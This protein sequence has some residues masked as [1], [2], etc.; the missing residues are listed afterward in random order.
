MLDAAHGASMS[1]E[2]IRVERGDV[3]GSEVHRS[4]TDTAGSDRRRR[5][6]KPV[7]ADIRQYCRRRVADARSRDGK[8]SL[9]GIP[10]R[11]FLFNE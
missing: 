7:R 8:Q 10:E 3:A 5:P 9:N 1:T 4:R 11:T 2:S 6:R